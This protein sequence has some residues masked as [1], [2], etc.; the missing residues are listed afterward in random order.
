MSKKLDV[1]A[2]QGKAIPNGVSHKAQASNSSGVALADYASGNANE[3][4]SE[5]YE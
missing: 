3:S 5:V 4:A 2:M 1:Y